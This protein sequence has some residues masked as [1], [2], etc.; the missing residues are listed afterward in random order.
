MVISIIFY[1]FF[2]SL[3]YYTMKELDILQ[4]ED[5]D[6]R[7]ALFSSFVWPITWLI[8]AICFLAKWIVDQIVFAV[9]EYKR[10]KREKKN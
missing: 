5:Y 7:P 3:S 6:G 8:L 9:D 4:G 10:E 1:I 2:M